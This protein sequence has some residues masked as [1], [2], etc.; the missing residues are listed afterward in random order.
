MQLRP[1]TT[2]TTTTTKMKAFQALKE[3]HAERSTVDADDD[4]V[5]S[6][7]QLQSTRLQLMVSNHP[8]S[9]SA[10]GLLKA[11]REILAAMKNKL[12]SIKFAKWQDTNKTGKKL[13]LV[14][15]IP[16]DIEKAELFLQNFSRFSKGKRGYFRI[17]VLHDDQVPTYLLEEVGK[18]FNVPQQQSLYL[19]SSDA[20][21]PQV[22]GLL[23]GSTEAMA[24]SLDT[25]ILLQKL[26]EVQV[27]GLTWKYVNNG[28]KGKFNPH[29]KA[30]Y[31]ETESETARTLKTF[32]TSYL[33]EEQQPIFGAAVTF[34]PSNQYPT[35]SQTSKIK[36][37]SPLQTNLISTLREYQVEIST[38]HSIPEFESDEE[39]SKDT[40]TTLVEL[41][42]GVESIVPK[43]VVTSKTTK[44]YNGKVFYAAITDLESNVTTFQFQEYNEQEATSILRALPLFIRDHFG[45]KNGKKLCRSSHVVAAM[46]G[47]WDKETRVFLSQQDLRESVQFENLE[48]LTQATT[49][50]KY[51]SADHQRLLMGAKLDD[52]SDITDLRNTTETMNDDPSALTTNTGS[53]RTSKAKAIA[54]QQVKEISRQYI[55]QQTEDKKRI[56]EQ[57]KQL[58]VQSQQMVAMQKMMQKIMHQTAKQTP[59]VAPADTLE[60]YPKE[61]QKGSIHTLSSSS[62]ASDDPVT[63]DSSNH[64]PVWVD[65]PKS[66][67]F[68]SEDD[69]ELDDPNERQQYPRDSVDHTSEDDDMCNDVD[70]EEITSQMTASP[71]TKKGRPPS[72]KRKH[73]D[74]VPPTIPKRTT[75][76]S[77]AGG[78]DW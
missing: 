5:P 76:S 66:H 11:V 58:N 22:I 61:L 17:Q 55:Q 77:T 3:I 6:G 60:E 24:N 45:F 35:L 26:S 39:E 30:I 1:N 68:D 52:A 13:A 31:I 38:F 53:T 63:S 78:R 36:K 9:T 27:I 19:A 47:Q 23:I 51:I 64:T 40:T 73:Q 42:L 54:E 15:Q 32:L 14:D 75:R 4:T 33:N 34:L 69:S 67:F 10:E 57:Q 59:T 21:N 25:R 70:H 16:S 49:Q 2:L 62:E 7:K 72:P 28:E 46:K 8:T 41:L 44:T 43:T 50:T 37:Y 74:T 65:K 56:E 71:K 20:V 12:P 18:S 48:L 29:Q